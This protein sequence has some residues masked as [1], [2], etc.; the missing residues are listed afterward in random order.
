MFLDCVSQ[1]CKVIVAQRETKVPQRREL[2]CGNIEIL[3]DFWNPDHFLR[4]EPHIIKGQCVSKV[5][6][7]G[8]TQSR[9]NENLLLL[10]LS[11]AFA[12]EVPRK[13]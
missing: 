5:F 7:C 4:E 13:Y 12:L 2:H 8:E 6:A 11:N 3:N 1:C 9:D 10:I